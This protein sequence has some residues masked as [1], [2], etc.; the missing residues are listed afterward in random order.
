M[1]P[2]YSKARKG[3]AD[4]VYILANEDVDSSPHVQILTVINPRSRGLSLL[5]GFEDF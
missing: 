4:C 2:S 3:T 5:A 1:V